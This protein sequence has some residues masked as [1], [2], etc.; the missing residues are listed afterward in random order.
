MWAALRILGVGKGDDNSSI[1]HFYF[2]RHCHSLAGAEAVFVDVEPDYWC[3]DVDAVEAAITEKTKAVIGVHIYGQPY[4]PRCW[5][6]RDKGISNRMRHKPGQVMWDG[7][8]LVAVRWAT[9]DVLVFPLKWRLAVK[10]Y[11]YRTVE[12]LLMQSLW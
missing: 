4:D 1:L 3:L 5:L 8:E 12:E 10:R 9:W 7:T 11:T 6:C 2:K